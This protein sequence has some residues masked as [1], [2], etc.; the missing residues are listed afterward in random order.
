MSNDTDYVVLLC[1]ETDQL[2]SISTACVLLTITK[3]GLS[4]FSLRVVV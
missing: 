1:T 4:F 2:P 3:K